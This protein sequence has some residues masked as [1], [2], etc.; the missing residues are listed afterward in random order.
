MKSIAIWESRNDK[1]PFQEIE[2]HFNY[3][4]IPNNDKNFHKFL[5][6]GL[7]LKS[8]QNTEYINFYFPAK[9]EK[10]DFCDIVSKFIKKPDLVS[11]IF[12]ENYKVVIEGSKQHKILSDQDDEVFTVYEF[13]DNDISFENK[14]GGT[15]VSLKVPKI[16]KKLYIRLRISGP[17]LNQLSTITSPSNSIFE[18]AFSE[19]EMIDFRVNE[20]RDLNKDLME[21]CGKMCHIEKQHFFYICSNSEDVIGYHTPYLSCRN[22][23]NYRWNGYVDLP[24]IENA[25]FL[26]YHWKWTNQENS[27]LL[28]KSKYEK[29]N[30][31]TIAKYLGVVVSISLVGCFL[32][33]IFKFLLL[34]LL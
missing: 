10:K 21:Y 4:K 17:F 26:A 1:Q 5:D 9:I 31:K 7:K 8:T 27:S 11:A 3:W 22:L 29:N 18:S 19:L 14:Y 12:N 28:I 6:V 33:D 23:E 16:N 15:I 32:Y 13:S 2:L 20:I 34:K 24:D 25:I 30:W